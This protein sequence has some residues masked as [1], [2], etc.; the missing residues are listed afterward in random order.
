MSKKTTIPDPEFTNPSVER[1]K[2]PHIHITPSDD[3]QQASLEITSGRKKIVM[4]LTEEQ[5]ASLIAALGAV[6]QVMVGAEVPSLEG[7]SF[8]PVR[9]THWAL[10]LDSASQGSVLAFQH[11]A[12]GPVGLALTPADSSKLARGLTLHQQLNDATLKASG[13]AN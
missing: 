8:I 4:D 12:Y 1:V 2:A 13:P 5:V 11:P 7:V 3:R 10:Q 6:H 9:R